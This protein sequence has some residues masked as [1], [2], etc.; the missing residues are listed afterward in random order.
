MPDLLRG[1][2]G[3]SEVECVDV[4]AVNSAG[5][6][7]I[8]LDKKAFSILSTSNGS[9]WVLIEG[10]LLISGLRCRICNIYAP[11]DVGDQESLWKTLLDLKQSSD[12]PFLVGGDFNIVLCLSERKPKHSRL[13]HGSSLFSNLVD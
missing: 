2:G 7:A 3:S 13:S 4:M 11:C 12:S 10:V 5:G 9:G 1:C 6:L 8:F